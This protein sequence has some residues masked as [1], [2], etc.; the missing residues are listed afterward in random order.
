MKLS[1]LMTEVA[2]IEH[3]IILISPSLPISNRMR[4]KQQKKTSYERAKEAFE[5]AREKRRK[6]KEV[7]PFN[8]NKGLLSGTIRNFSKMSSMLTL[9]VGF[10]SILGVPEEQTAE[11]R[12]H[13]AVQKEKDGKLSDPQQKDKERT[14]QSQSPNGVFA[15]KDP[16]TWKVNS[17]VKETE[18]KRTDGLENNVPEQ[19][20]L[21]SWICLKCGVFCTVCSPFVATRGRSWTQSGKHK[22]RFSFQ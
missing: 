20:W 5:A 7:M 18:W 12:G 2:E 19:S 15:S 13:S 11:R 17:G 4:K 14:A 21:P 3:W 9:N 16:G 6:K 10:C 1:C 22:R 8:K